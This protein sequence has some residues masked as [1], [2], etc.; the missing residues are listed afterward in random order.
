MAVSQ[1]QN[2]RD[3]TVQTIKELADIVE[4]IGEHVNLKKSGVNLKGLCPFH[5]EKTPSFMVNP[6][7]KSFHCFGC[8]EGGD[9]FTFVMNFHRLTFPE[10]LK[11]LARR[12]QITLPEENLSPADQA[13]AQKRQILHEINEQAA[14]AFHDHLLHSSDAEAARNYLQERKINSE[15]IKSF[16]LGYAPDSWDF[17]IKKLSNSYSIEDM[18]DAG[19]VVAKDKGGFY[20]RFRGRILFP[21]FS[22]TGKIIGFGGRILGDGQPKYLN[23]PETL[24]FDKSRT[25]FGIYQNKESVRK[26]KKC[27]IVEGNFDLLS[28]VVHGI[29][30]VVAPLGTA[31]TQF[32]VR[33]LKGY[34]EEAIL[35]FDGDT[36][37]LKA[38]M[39]AV[40]IFLTEQ[41]TSKI[42]VLPESHDPDTFVN[43]FGKETLLELLNNAM[44]LPEFI[45]SRLVEQYGLTLEGKGKIVAE[46]QPIINAIGDQQLQRTLFVSHFSKKLDLTHE[47][48][49]SGVRSKTS[50]LSTAKKEKTIKSLHLPRKQVQLLEFLI[51]YPEYLQDFVE[52]G[53]DDVIVDSYGQNILSHLKTFIQQ[54]SGVGP[55]GLLAMTGGPEKSFISKLLVSTPS[56]PDEIKEATA[57]EMIS[58][59]QKISIKTKKDRLI[60]QINEAHK[61]HNETL[62][63]ELMEQKKKMDE[64]AA[65]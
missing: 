57:K 49:L 41:L 29:N 63:M 14:I 38:A 24:I 28:L 46:L 23:T 13:K 59:L 4:I 61:S 52:A 11:D 26:E 50:P 51:L 17:I 2:H 44:S 12:Y 8:G 21:I 20:D 56:Y 27:I 58:W 10:A 6:E 42:A 53:I 60:N 40:P 37:G 55:E 43:Q 7:R 47:Q 65:N 33:S 3:D 34:S 64:A 35:L 30:N 9:V 22:L 48:L 62:W 16:Q 15:I 32:H 1:T 36:A 18:K 45:F 39:R 25:L 5:S 19:L 54:N 31:L